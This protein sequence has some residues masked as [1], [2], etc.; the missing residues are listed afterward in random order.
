MPGPDT[1]FAPFLVASAVALLSS[2]CMTF[3]QV[4]LSEAPLTPKERIPIACMEDRGGR[5]AELVEGEIGGRPAVSVSGVR[6][7]YSPTLS[8]PMEIEGAR[9]FAGEDCLLRHDGAICDSGLY[10][11]RGDRRY[12][13]YWANLYKE[14]QPLAPSSKALVDQLE[15]HK[16]VTRLRNLEMDDSTAA[17]F[18]QL[19]ASRGQRAQWRLFTFVAGAALDAAG[20]VGGGGLTGEAAKQA[21]ETVVT[22]AFQAD[23]S[24]RPLITAHPKLA[25]VF[26]IATLAGSE[27]GFNIA[28]FCMGPAGAAKPAS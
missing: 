1:Q 27:N 9:V 25:S 21:K 23:E 14:Q 5:V 7:G 11:R 24:E 3:K 19:S 6:I 20:P 22:R 10:V 16:I 12:F 17:A 18:E 26:E 13:L 8:E 28:T 15:K 4:G 2:G